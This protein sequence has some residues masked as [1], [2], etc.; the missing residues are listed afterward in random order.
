MDNS[1]KETDYMK[2]NHFLVF[3]LI[4]L[5]MLHLGCATQLPMPAGVQELSPGDYEKLTD[6]KT[7]RIEIY[8][9]LH[10]KM[11]VSATWLDSEMSNG[12]LSHSARLAQWQESKYKEERYKVVARHT[13]RTEFFVS[14]YTPERKLADLANKK[15]LWKIYLDVNGQRFEGT[16]TKVKQLLTEIQAIY[17]QHNRWSTPFIV[18]FPVSTALTENKEATLT[19][20]GAVGS[21]QV[22]FSN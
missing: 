20:T 4:V 22:R 15:N 9:G 2:S 7:Q 16:A 10:N 11:T 17:P 3:A 8:E 1:A 6:R 14:F 5:T 19:M 21:A 18:S 13:D 12:T